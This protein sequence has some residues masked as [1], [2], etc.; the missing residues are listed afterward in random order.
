MWREAA[1]VILTAAKPVPECKQALRAVGD[2][3]GGPDW[4]RAF[5]YQVLMLKRSSKSSFMPNAYVFPGGVL[6]KHDFSK[7]WM[8]LL[9][10]NGI[11]GSDLEEL[12]LENK[13]R[14]FLMG[15][16]SPEEVVR[17]DIA[18]RLTALRETFEESGILLYRGGDNATA[19]HIFQ[20][21]LEKL[22]VKVHKDPSELLEL[23]KS[24]DLVPDL[25]G[26]S[27]WSDWLTPTDLHEQGKRR[28]DTLFYVAHLPSIPETILDQA[29]I[30]AV[31]W[32]TPAAILSS[33]YNRQLWLAPP[34][35]YELCRLL[36]FSDQQQLKEF[37]RTRHR[38]G[39]ITWL[40]VRLQCD[41]GL[42]SILPGDSMYPEDP[43]YHGDQQKKDL[44]VYKGS[45]QDCLE[46]SAQTN[47]LVFKDTYDCVPTVTCEPAHGQVNPVQFHKFQADR[48]NVMTVDH[49]SHC[50][51][52]QQRFCKKQT[53]VGWVMDFTEKDLKKNRNKNLKKAFET[54]Q[55]RLKDL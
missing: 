48:F 43:D 4:N 6:S 51:E 54:T 23:Y 22:R 39:C 2:I 7:G 49:C 35:V 16:A 3:G 38:E 50:S 44:T 14:P 55:E 1:S 52:E 21:D 15:D 53:N 27:E 10:G 40:P 19:A 34:Q 37:T 28:F 5:N 12:V 45:M 29:E 24:L 9:K 41:D 13:D 18:F 31:E 36:N 42:L 11:S 32:T 25:W 26:L 30:S 47:R 33:F 17:R 46:A 8:D 20:S